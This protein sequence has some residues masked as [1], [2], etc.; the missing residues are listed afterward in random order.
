MELVQLAQQIVLHALLLLFA[1]LAKMEKFMTLQNKIQVIHAKTIVLKP[2][3]LTLF[4]VQVHVMLLL[5][6]FVPLI[7]LVPEFTRALL[8]IILQPLE[9]MIQIVIQHAQQVA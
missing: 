7:L 4:N 1:Q 8:D 2:V 3:K 6:Q 9:L 5:H